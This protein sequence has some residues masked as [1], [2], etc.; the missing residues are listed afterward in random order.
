ML[1]LVNTVATD[2]TGPKRAG[3]LGLNRTFSLLQLYRLASESTS[4]V[5][6]KVQFIPFHSS[7]AYKHKFIYRSPEL[8]NILRY[9]PGPVK[10]C[11]ARLWSH[12]SVFVLLAAT[13]LAPLI[14]SLTDTNTHH[15][16]SCGSATPE[17]GLGAELRVTF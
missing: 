9:R 11:S 1:H 14:P 5:G 3:Q 13:S 16:T 2:L 6:H 10:S 15:S 17:P 7:L 12:S 4:L 8:P